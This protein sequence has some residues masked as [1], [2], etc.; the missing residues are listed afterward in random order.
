MDK[1]DKI[2]GC[3]IGLAIGVHLEFTAPGSFIPITD[4]TEGNPY[5]I[6]KGYWTDDT[7]MALCMA[8][9]LIE[10]KGF[11]AEDIMKKFCE[12]QRK[13]YRSS[14]GRCFDIGNTTRSA[15]FAYWSNPAGGP[16]RG[17]TDVLSAGNGSIM[18]LAPIPIFY[19]NDE[20]AAVYLSGE[21]SRITHGN[22]NCI[23][24]CRAL[25]EIIYRGINTAKENS[26]SYDLSLLGVTYPVNSKLIKDVV[27][28]SYCNKLNS[29]I[30]GSGYVVNSLEAALWAY[31][32]SDSFEDAVLKAVNLGDDADTTGAV[33][34]QI[35][36]AFYGYD[37]IPQ[38]LKE[39]LYQHDMIVELA[40]KLYKSSLLKTQ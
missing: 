12:W 18:R 28:G 8:D 32:N 5:S 9:S 20:V 25:A 40:E 37:A 29:E 1:L 26:S 36:G 11:D 13:G 4:Y 6:P 24:A 2:K 30:R 21:S 7:S 22:S 35:A 14:T 15:L 34:G 39:G 10:K 23:E 17:F 3:L 16:F 19:H 38:H 31:H 27:N 33:C